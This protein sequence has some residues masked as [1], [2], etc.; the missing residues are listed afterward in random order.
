MLIDCKGAEIRILGISE[1]FLL[2]LRVDKKLNV[3]LSGWYVLIKVS[4]SF[5]IKCESK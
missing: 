5:K 1:N 4:E 2:I 3:K